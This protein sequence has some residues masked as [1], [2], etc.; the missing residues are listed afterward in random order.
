MAV[1]ESILKWGRESFNEDT[2]TTMT[3]SSATVL[4]K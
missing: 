4:N 1:F 3:A 2:L